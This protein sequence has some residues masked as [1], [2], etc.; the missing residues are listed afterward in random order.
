MAHL[1]SAT[2]SRRPGTL[3]LRPLAGFQRSSQNNEL[4]MLSTDGGERTND[5]VM[6]QGTVLNVTHWRRWITFYLVESV[7]YMYYDNP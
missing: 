4:I 5:K 2:L 3:N 7:H 6:E 1:R